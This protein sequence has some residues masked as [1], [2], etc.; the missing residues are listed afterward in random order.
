MHL[1]VPILVSEWDEN[2]FT[3]MQL[4]NNE[5]NAVIKGLEW[6]TPLCNLLIFAF[7]ECQC[8]PEVGKKI[9]V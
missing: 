5:T 2:L 3:A 7:I 8:S 4:L 9:G 1:L 6:G